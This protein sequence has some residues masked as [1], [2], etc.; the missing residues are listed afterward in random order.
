VAWRRTKLPLLAKAMQLNRDTEAQVKLMADRPRVEADYLQTKA[1]WQ[2]A[3]DALNPQLLPLEEALKAAK[4]A[5]PK[6]SNLQGCVFALLCSVAGISGFLVICSLG[7]FVSPGPLGQGDWILI[8]IS[9]PPFLISSALAIWLGT[10]PKRQKKALLADIR[11]KI[12]LLKSS[13]PPEPSLPPAPTTPADEHC[14]KFLREEKLGSNFTDLEPIFVEKRALVERV[15]EA[16]AA[17]CKEL[18]ELDAR[19]LLQSTAQ[20]VAA[21]M[22]L[23]L[24]PQLAIGAKG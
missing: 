19:D 8:S 23:P 3:R 1:A 18:D 5:S 10:R 20:A 17:L 2:A 6:L 24:P 15:L 14:E 22:G 21:K 11:C 9:W 16:D 12:A 13:L 7:V 4:A